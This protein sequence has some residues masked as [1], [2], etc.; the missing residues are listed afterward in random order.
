VH[1]TDRFGIDLGHLAQDYS[2]IRSMDWK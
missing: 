1:P 2:R